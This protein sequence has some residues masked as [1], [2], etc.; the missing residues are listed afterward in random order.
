M[1]ADGLDGVIHIVV[2]RAVVRGQPSQY[3]GGM[4]TRSVLTHVAVLAGRGGAPRRLRRERHSPG[5]QRTHRYDE[6]RH[7]LRGDQ[8]PTDAH[9]L[10]RE[11]DGA[12]RRPRRP[13]PALFPRPPRP[14]AKPAP[15]P[16]SAPTSPR[17]TAPGR[18][19]QPQLGAL[20]ASRLARA[21]PPASTT[22]SDLV[23]KKHRYD[24][25]PATITERPPR[26][27][28]PGRALPRDG[29]VRFKRR[30]TWSTSRARW[31]R[32]TARQPSA[33]EVALDWSDGRWK[34][35]TIQARRMKRRAAIAIARCTVIACSPLRPTPSAELD[36]RRSVERR[37]Q[38]SA[39]KKST[40]SETGWI[41]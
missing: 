17:S 38:P 36:W 30:A 31:S 2:L 40:E 5:R 21:A 39:A 4:V 27:R 10:L 25:A 23:A 29:Q 8:H 19:R 35:E 12:P 18:L 41:P 24:G 34:I 22:A 33:L 16:S 9:C 28:Q 6:P 20:R 7:L 15:K 32:R 26:L 14:T 3:V 11:A 1:G 37:H 13:R